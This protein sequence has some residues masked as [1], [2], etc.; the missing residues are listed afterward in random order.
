MLKA[1]RKKK[2]RQMT[3]KWH[4]CNFIGRHD[5]GEKRVKNKERAER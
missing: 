5:E 4:D 1:K 3:L 2:K